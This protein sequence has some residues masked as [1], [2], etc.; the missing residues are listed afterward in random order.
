MTSTVTLPS[1][2]KYNYKR[3]WNLSSLWELSKDFEVKQIRVNELWDNRYA[4]AWCWQ[5]E[6]EE[7]NQLF[8]LHH[9]NRILNADLSYP[10]I[11]SEEDYIF[12][13]VHRL[14]KAKHLNLEY[15]NYVKFKKDPEPNYEPT[16]RSN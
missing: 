14:M 10:I 13:G 1:T 2:K 11:L 16:E 3:Q 8:F 7:I 12:D 4:K 6:D 5:H 15:I 9:M